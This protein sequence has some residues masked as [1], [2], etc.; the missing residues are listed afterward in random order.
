MFLGDPV[1][2]A[3]FIKKLFFNYQFP[4]FQTLNPEFFSKTQQKS[5]FV[6]YKEVPYAKQFFFKPKRPEHSR[7]PTAARVNPHECP[8][9]D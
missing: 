2:R 8:E 9:S 7:P 6:N 3:S 1:K 4:K 5:I